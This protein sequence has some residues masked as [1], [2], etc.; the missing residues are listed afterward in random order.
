MSKDLK[1][2]R[3]LTIRTSLGGSP[4]QRKKT[5]QTWKALDQTEV[6]FFGGGWEGILAVKMMKRELDTYFGSKT[7]LSQ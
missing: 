4:R 5:I 6:N 2:V 7:D 3:E 1:E